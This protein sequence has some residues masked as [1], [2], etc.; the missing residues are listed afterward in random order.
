MIKVMCNLVN[1]V[2]SALRQS[3]LPPENLEIEVTESVLLDKDAGYLQA[4][5]Q[6]RSIGVTIALDDFGTGYSSFGYL[7]QFAFDKL[8]IDR[9][10][11]G[12]VAKPGICL[13]IISAI[14]G[15]SRGL[16][17]ETTAEGVETEEQLQILRAGGVTYAQGYLFGKAVPIS[18]LRKDVIGTCQVH[19]ARRA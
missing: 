8:K 18:E 19:H 9:S 17:I 2:T 6:L 4:L 5:N 13:A 12:D 11:T 7:K 14:I 3:G 10:F 1:V 15:L 16:Q